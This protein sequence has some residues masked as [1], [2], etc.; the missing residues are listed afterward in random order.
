MKHNIIIATGGTGGHIIPARAFAIESSKKHNTVVLADKKYKFYLKKDDQFKSLVVSSSQI[1]ARVFNGIKAIFK[2][3]FGVIQ[4][5]FF[6]LKYR[7][8]CI[9]SFG[10]YATFPV[11]IAGFLTRRKIII[12]EQ[13]ACFGKVNRYFARFSNKI[14]LTFEDTN[15]IQKEFLAKCKVVGIPLRQEIVAL[16]EIEYTL[17]KEYVFDKKNKMG[18]DVILASEL[19]EEAS[20]E[21]FKILVLG[22][23]GGAKI[24][25]DILPKAMFNLQDETKDNIFI[26]QQCRRDQVESTFKQYKSFNI[27]VLINSFFDNMDEI[28]SSS[29]LIIARAGASSIFEFCCAKKPMILVPFSNS[30]DN[31]QLKNARVLEKQGSAIV[32]EEK[33]FTI[34]NV[35]S[36]IKNIINNHKLL[37]T[38]SDNSAKFANLNGSKNLI[39]L[40]ENSLI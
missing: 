20:D 35:N 21:R 16:N 5:L 3:F 11:L 30:A 34:N 1:E 29:H 9:V 19:L 8:D 4:S 14:A 13:N 32:I 23:S 17:P 31:H 18:Y 27:S 25:S 39:E 33:Y 2:I 22:G 40:I 37:K 28:L 6:I 38:M 36:V 24:F 26:T 12:H 7:A 15:F 10:G